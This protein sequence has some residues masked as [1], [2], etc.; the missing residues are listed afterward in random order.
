MSS[1]F[2][3]CRFVSHET[4][5]LNYCL[6]LQGCSKLIEREEAMP[7]EIPMFRTGLGK[8]V[9]LKE[10]SIAKA[11]SILAEKVAYSGTLFDS[12]EFT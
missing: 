8:S 5:R 12:I 4:R 11:K 2:F 6:M 10:S 7:G 3:F 9:A 1:F